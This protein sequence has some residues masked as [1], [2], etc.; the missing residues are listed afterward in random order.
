MEIVLFSSL[1]LAAFFMWLIIAKNRL[2]EPLLFCTIL[3]CSVL[4]ITLELISAV[5]AVTLINIR[6]ALI[7]VSLFCG[8]V[9][10]YLQRQGAFS[11]EIPVTH[12][13]TVSRSLTFDPDALILRRTLAASLLFIVL[14][15]TAVTALSSVPNNWDSM[16]YHLPRIEHW[17]QNRS[18]E[19][20]PTSIIRQLERNILAEKLILVFRSVSGAY[21][22]ANMVQW[23]SFCGCILVVGSIA[24]ELGGSRSAQYLSSVMMSMLPMAILQSSSTQVDLVAAFFGVASVYFLLRVRVGRPYFL[25]Y[26]AVL[27][28]ALAWHAKGTAAVYLSG[29]VA[30][31]GGGLVLRAKSPDSGSTRRW[32]RLSHC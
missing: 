29:F 7:G 27:A 10:F 19:F 24:R 31:Y 16:T 8:T 4:A 9:T 11:E 6:I 18:L 5:G 28:A 12:H 22:V 13:S 21:P 15:A 17:L 1:A 25:L 14:T 32:Q 23:L 2:A 3:I 26:S 30:V 20:Y